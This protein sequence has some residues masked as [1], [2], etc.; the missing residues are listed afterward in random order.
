MFNWFYWAI[1]IGALSSIITTNVEKYYSFWL[2]YLLPLIVFNGAIAVL[3]FGRKRYIQK[4]PGGSLIIRAGRVTLKA[5]RMR[6]KL[7]KQSGRSHLLD[8]AKEIPSLNDYDGKLRVT[9]T[10][11][12]QFIDELKKAGGACRVFVF[13]PFYWVCYNQLG[14]NLVSQAA[15]MNVGELTF[16]IGMRDTK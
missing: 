6:W 10:E 2:A 11:N 1:N 5:I 14:T 8:Y 3:I 12:N 15:Q 4:P 7:G 16:S 9:E 13:Y